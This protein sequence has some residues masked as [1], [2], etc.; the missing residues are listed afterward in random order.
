MC[1]F[2]EEEDFGK[3]NSL[4]FFNMESFKTH[5]FIFFLNC[6]MQD[7]IWLFSGCFSPILQKIQVRNTRNIFYVRK[8]FSKGINKKSSSESRVYTVLTILKMRKILLPKIRTFPQISTFPIISTP[9][10]TGRKC[11]RYEWAQYIKIAPSCIMQFPS[12]HEI[13]T[14]QQSSVYKSNNINESLPKRLGINSITIVWF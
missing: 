3:I 10:L 4:Y 1:L 9:F 11:A 8:F 2:G 5:F 7:W 6:V 14:I 13:E 12:I